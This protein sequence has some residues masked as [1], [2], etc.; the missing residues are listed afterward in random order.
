MGK[1]SVVLVVA[2]SREMKNT[3]KIRHAL[4]SYAQY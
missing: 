1:T 2:L 3:G 4:S